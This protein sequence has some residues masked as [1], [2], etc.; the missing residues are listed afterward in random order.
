MIICDMFA[1]KIYWDLLGTWND[2]APSKD[3]TH[4]TCIHVNMWYFQN[5]LL[6]IGFRQHQGQYPGCKRTVLQI[7]PGG[8]MKVGMLG[9]DIAYV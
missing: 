3:H 9:F 4:V 7:E 8:I 1:K 6:Y 5:K 2:D